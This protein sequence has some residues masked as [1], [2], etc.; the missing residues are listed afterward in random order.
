LEVF[1]DRLDGLTLKTSLQDGLAPVRADA[2]LL[3]SVIVNLI[4]NAAEALE[5]ASVRQI[6]VSTR[7]RAES[8]T[9]EIAVS[10]TGHGISPQDKDKLFL[11]HFS[12]KER[13]TGL[14]LAIAARII[15]EHGGSL[16][17]EDNLPQGSRFIIEL[18]VAETVSAV[19]VDRSGMENGK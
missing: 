11:P 13:G 2:A 17:V 19:G 4:D 9:I 5:N 8:D 12:T 6:S 15:S 3:R 14:G 7:L 10:D 18:P 16:R 1:S